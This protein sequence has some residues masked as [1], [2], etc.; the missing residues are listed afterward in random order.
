MLMLLLNSLGSTGFPLFIVKGTIEALEYKEA[1]VFGGHLRAQLPQT[2]LR[3][4]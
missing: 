3:G 2:T 1:K 4:N